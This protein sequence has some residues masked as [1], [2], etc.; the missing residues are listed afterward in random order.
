MEATQSPS[1]HPGPGL[2]LGKTWPWPWPGE[3][4]TLFK[5]RGFPRDGAPY[6]TLRT[7]NLSS[8]AEKFPIAPSFPPSSFQAGP[9]PSQAAVQSG[10][11][12]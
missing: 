8:V 9:A 2:L 6:R 7:S 12:G 3:R 4:E 1:F 11:E 5:G 10:P